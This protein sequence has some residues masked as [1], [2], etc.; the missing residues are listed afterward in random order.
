[1]MKPA[2]PVIDNHKECNRCHVTKQVSEFSRWKN[3]S[4]LY[5]PTPDCKKC[6]AEYA[7]NRNRATGTKP[8]TE[9]PVIDGHKECADCHTI[10]PIPEYWKGMNATGTITYNRLCKI[11]MKK[12]LIT[13]ARVKGVQPMKKRLVIDGHSECSTCHVMKPLSDYK[14]RKKKDGSPSPEA[15]CKECTNKKQVERARLKGVQPKKYYPVING[16]KLCGKCNVTKPISEYSNNRCHCKE[17]MIV[18]Y[19]KK[20]RAKGVKLNKWYPVIDG[21]KQCT[22]CNEVKPITN[23]YKRAINKSGL[24]GHCIECDL[25]E[26]LKWRRAKGMI[27]NVEIRYPIIDG[28]KKCY[29][30]NEN[31]AVEKFSI[32]D[33]NLRHSCK[34]CN[35]KKDKPY[36]IKYYKRDSEGLTDGYLAMVIRRHVPIHKK[37]IPEDIFHIFREK[38]KIQRELKQLKSLNQ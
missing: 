21:C 30:C 22:R 5:I 13:K 1:M 38:I 8:R 10:K 31:L 3:V 24:L 20:R 14:L 15:H 19:I 32:K 27:P 4:G 37:D 29:L 12:S 28:F 16:M 17:C 34:T 11:C 36:R 35:L 33:G 25:Q 26:A 9:Y 6:R 7:M 2:Y 23:F 18:Y